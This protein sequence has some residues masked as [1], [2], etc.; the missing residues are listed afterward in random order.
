M[1]INKRNLNKLSEILRQLPE[2]L[3]SPQPLPPKQ[4]KNQRKLHRIET[5][6]DPS[7]LFYELINASNDA[8]IP[9]HMIK[10]LKE[11]E[12]KQI[13][14]KGTNQV[15][16]NSNST[17]HKSNFSKETEEL[18]TSFQMMLLEEEEEEI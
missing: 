10:R 17:M 5:E 6:E 13:T 7:N 11:I 8:N 3:P 15:K 12:N 4:N 1:S 14:S 16:T 18:Y 9:S 2:P